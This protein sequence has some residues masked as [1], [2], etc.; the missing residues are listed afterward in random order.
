MVAIEHATPEAIGARLREE[1][2]ADA[3]QSRVEGENVAVGRI[4]AR[5][6]ADRIA[7]EVVEPGEAALERVRERFGDGV[8][9]VERVTA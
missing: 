5:G 1:A 6:D 3:A 7:R 8:F 2:L 4:E 9:D